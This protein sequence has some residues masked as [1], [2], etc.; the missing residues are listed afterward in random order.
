MKWDD[1]YW[2]RV[3]PAGDGSECLI[4]QGAYDSN[5]HPCGR[6]DGGVYTA[7][8][9]SWVTDNGLLSDGPFVSTCKT[10]GCV[11]VN[12]IRMKSEDPM[13]DEKKYGVRLDDGFDIIN[14]SED[15][16]LDDQAGEWHGD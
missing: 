2:S 7:Y 10:P 9:I 13:F 12:H 16:N 15:E 4:W 1:Y 8:Q 5:G 14:S 3:K 6:I 11:C